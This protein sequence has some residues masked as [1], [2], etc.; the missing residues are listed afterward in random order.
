MDYKLLAIRVAGLAAG[1]F[2]LFMAIMGL[3]GKASPR[4]VAVCVLLIVNLPAIL[5][6]S[7]RMAEP[8][9]VLEPQE[10][11]GMSCEFCENPATV[12]V[13]DLQGGTPHEHHVCQGHVWQYLDATPLP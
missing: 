4:W 11:F 1:A 10:G 13:T 3:L 5:R 2:F 8:C 9:N 12:H 7:S 6:R